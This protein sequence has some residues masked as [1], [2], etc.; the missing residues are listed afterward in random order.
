MS[1][2]VL[3]PNGTVSAVGVTITGAATAHAALSDSSDTSYAELN[4]SGEL[5]RLN[6]TTASLPAGAVGVDIGPIVRVAK[7]G[8]SN[9]GVVRHVYG[10]PS[11]LSEGLGSISWTSPL[12]LSS[13]GM[14]SAIATVA[15][16]IANIANLEQGVSQNGAGTLRVYEASVAVAYA[17]QPTVTVDGPATPVSDTNTPTVEWTGTFDTDNG[18]LANVSLGTQTHY[19]VKV[20]TDA[21]YG[22]GGFDPDTSTPTS[23]SGIVASTSESWQVADLLPDDTYRAYV[24]VAQTP[25]SV[26]DPT[27]QHWSDWDYHEFTLTVALPAAPTLTLTPD[28]ANGRIIAELDDNAGDATTDYFQ[29]QRSVDG[30]DTWTDVR[31]LTDDTLITPSAGV[32]TVYDYELPNGEAVDYRARAAHNYSGVLAY[33]A[34]TSAVTSWSGDVWWIKDPLDPARNLTVTVLAYNEVQRPARQGVFQ[35][36]GATLPLVVSDTRGGATGTIILRTDSAA[37]RAALDN[38][39]DRTVLIQGPAA[40]GE[41]DRYVRLGDT[42]RQR[43]D[44]LR[45]TAPQRTE[46]LAWVEVASPTGVVTEWPAGD[47]PTE[48]LVMI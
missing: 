47:G 16:A 29:L 46:S 4:A 22:A 9:P 40:D 12:E 11:S 25:S 2:L 27:Y 13:L 44:G 3:T 48:E 45:S 28:S 42:A 34:W 19:E 43:I 26:W 7:S 8:A 6:L 18:D 20:F 39:L 1:Q 24:R 32:A 33:S 21:Q 41:P 23:E 38:V 15:T 30:G 36:L 35:A 17:D 14:N 37:D 31:L 5:V 10:L